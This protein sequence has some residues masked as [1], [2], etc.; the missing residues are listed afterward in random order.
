M[1]IKAKLI[2]NASNLDD[3]IEDAGEPFENWLAKAESVVTIVDFEALNA[4]M[5]AR[6]EKL[7]KGM[8]MHTLQAVVEG[9]IGEMTVE[10]QVQAKDV[11]QAMRLAAMGLNASG[12]A[13]KELRP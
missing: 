10:I 6:I 13:F 1:S 2:D 4:E 5:Y 7:F 3:F 8:P 11:K 12:I 9:P